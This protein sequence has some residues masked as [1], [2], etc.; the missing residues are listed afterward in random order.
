M[1]VTVSCLGSWF[2]SWWTSHY[3]TM[4]SATQWQQSTEFVMRSRINND[5]GLFLKEHLYDPGTVS[6][7]W[8]AC[9]ESKEHYCATSILVGASKFS[10]C[11]YSVYLFFSLSLFLSFLL[12]P[13]LSL[14]LSLF[15][16]PTFSV[17]FFAHPMRTITHLVPYSIAVRQ[18][19]PAPLFG[20]D[21]AWGWGAIGTICKHVSMYVFIV[22][23]LWSLP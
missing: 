21:L 14:S 3:I 4:S 17:H 18:Y 20:S 2:R 11:P 5:E 6:G 12:S 1:V 15:L 22:D 23:Q 9:T 13:L 19:L 7:W 16:W 8:L 10:L